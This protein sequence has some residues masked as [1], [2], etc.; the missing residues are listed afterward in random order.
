M[1]KL[2]VL[3]NNPTGTFQIPN[4]TLRLF[5]TQIHLRTEYVLRGAARSEPSSTVAGGQG[6][7][8][9]LT[10]RAGRAY[11]ALQLDEGR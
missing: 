11:P 5:S 9:P 3:T 10:T 8:L 2:R 1:S 6:T 7:S 4:A